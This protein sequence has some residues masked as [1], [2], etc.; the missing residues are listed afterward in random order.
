MELSVVT[1]LYK[2]LPFL[3]EFLKEILKAI[4]ETE[5]QKFEIVFVN[6]G[7]PDLS[8]DFLKEKQKNIPQIVIINLSRNFGH[9]HAIMAGLSESQG[10]K[11]FLIDNDL[12]VSPHF[13][14]DCLATM[15]KDLS[16]DVVY[17]VQ[18]VRKGKLVEKYGGMIFW[19]AINKFSEV[20][21][22]KNITTE[23]LMTRQYVKHLL[24]L[25]DANL[26]LGGMMHWVGFNQIGIT[27]KKGIR[28]GDSTYSTRKRLELMMH[29]V[30]SFSG[31]PLAYL[32]NLGVIITFLS[33]LG[34]IALLLQ[35][36]YC[37][38]A[39]QL[40]WTSIVVINFLI[41]GIISTSLG[42]IGMYLFKV[43]KQV[44][45]RPQFIIKNRLENT[46]NKI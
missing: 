41:L 33:M 11:I 36:L 18:D 42:I 7:S 2:S 37:G 6:D 13:L 25:G 24:S 9:H 21:V 29:A 14:L 28:E 17:G 45:S 8:V 15:K 23:R 12:E 20:K 38:S 1:T 27:T 35:K 3:D 31:K 39:V 43:Y 22:P 34:I 44:Q 5:I 19:W 30:T 40:G 32:F 26:F 4:K 16:I 10:E 46:S